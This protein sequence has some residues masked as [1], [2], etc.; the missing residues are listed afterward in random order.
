MCPI[1]A[2]SAVFDMPSLRHLVLHDLQR[3]CLDG[4]GGYEG[5]LAAFSPCLPRLELL[6][7]HGRRNQ[8]RELDTLLLSC[9]RL[10]V[11]GS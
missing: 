4:T 7:L 9:E 2:G 8:T 10:Q 3:P 1:A 11:R 6:A 5:G